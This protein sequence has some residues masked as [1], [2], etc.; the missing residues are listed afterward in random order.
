MAELSWVD[1]TVH[2]YPSVV[3]ES[4]LKA[5]CLAKDTLSKLFKIDSNLFNHWTGTK[6]AVDRLST[7]TIVDIAILSTLRTQHSSL[8]EL[9]SIWTQNPTV[10][11]WLR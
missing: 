3:N 11:N 4:K 6:L 7:R 8:A 5:M 1:P 2:F 10:I 9:S